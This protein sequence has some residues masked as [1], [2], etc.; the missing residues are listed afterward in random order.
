MIRFTSGV[1]SRRSVRN[2]FSNSAS[3]ANCASVIKLAA[4]CTAS[5]STAIRMVTSSWKRV[6][7]MTGTPTGVLGSISPAT[8]APPL[9]TPQ[10]LHGNPD[11][12]QFLETCARHDGDAHGLVG[13]Y[14][15]R[16]FGRQFLNR[17]PDRHCTGAKRAGHPC[18]REPLPRL[19]LA[20]ND[21]LPQVLIHP[22]RQGEVNEGLHLL[23][24]HRTFF[25]SAMWA[26]AAQ[27]AC[28]LEQRRAPCFHRD[29]P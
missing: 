4:V 29:F 11:G 2:A 15:Q 18:Q 7:V 24:C 27:S 9:P 23:Q 6:R 12:D 5:P 20:R 14:L 28:A 21:A 16:T 22:G 1:A 19:Y 17:F 10:P 13:K 26:C 8:P 3:R 25:T